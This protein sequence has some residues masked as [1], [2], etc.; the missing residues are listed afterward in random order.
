MKVPLPYLIAGAG[1][2]LQHVIATPIRVVVV[3]GH[4]EV[5]TVRI[6]HAAA[7]GLDESARITYPL[8]ANNGRTR[9]GQGRCSKL[10]LKEKLNGISDTLKNALGWPFIETLPRIENDPNLVH[11]L[12]VKDFPDAPVLHGISYPYSDNFLQA[13]GSHPNHNHHR[14]FRHRC[15]TF[16][17]RMHRALTSLGPWEGRAVSFVLGCGIGVLLRMFWVLGVVSYRIIRGDDNEP[18]YH[19]VCEHPPDFVC[20]HLPEEVFF[21]DQDGALYVQEP[22]ED[23]LAPP[24]IYADGENVKATNEKS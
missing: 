13:D 4:Q 14:H 12:P 24:P 9:I 23:M 15:G 6:G 17:K 19:L 18:E 7:N 1:L 3:T 21:M 11:I 16:L 10:K 2:V 22:T 8:D 20:E 5:P